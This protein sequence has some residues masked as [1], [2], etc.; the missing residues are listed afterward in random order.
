MANKVSLDDIPVWYNGWLGGR[1]TLKLSSIMGRRWGRMHRGV[2]IPVPVGTIVKSPVDGRV[3]QVLNSRTAGRYLKIR[4]T[5]AGANFDLIFMHLSRIV[6]STGTTVKSGQTVAYSGN[7]GRS[8]GPHIHVELHMGAATINP[9][10]FFY[11]KVTYNSKTLSN[12]RRYSTVKKDTVE[13]VQKY[14]NTDI[15]NTVDQ[16]AIEQDIVTTTT[17][18]IGAVGERLAPGIWQITKLIMDTSVRNRQLFDSSIAFQTGPLIN[19]FRKVCQMPFVELMGDTYGDQYYFMVRKPPYDKEGVDIMSQT[20]SIT[21]DPENIISTDLSWN[22]EGIY[23]W[24]QLVPYGDLFGG[25]NMYLYC[26]AIFFPEYAAVWGSKDFTIQSQYTNFFFSGKWEKTT[27]EEKRKNS[28][29]IIKNA[30]KDLKYMIE[31]NAYNPFVRR[32]TIVLNGDRRIKRGCTVIMPNNEQFYVDAVS[33]EVFYSETSVTRRTVLQVSHGMY[34]KFINGVEVNGDLMSYFNL[35]DFGTN[36][37]IK[38]ITSDNW[39]EALS[40]WKVNVNVFAYFLKRSQVLDAYI[41]QTTS[42]EK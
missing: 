42:T 14:A 37:D 10:P 28:E 11:E 29:N 23:S 15:T 21:I 26:P 35:I 40:K 32:G 13:S 3:M 22:T 27:D 12:G 41:S 1:K 2:D 34:Q 36:F 30:I 33:N 19:F 39:K 18:K 25:E 5:A 31:S 17:A 9:I 8:T 7:T 4:F 6:V 20:F 38:Q 24:Y 16:N